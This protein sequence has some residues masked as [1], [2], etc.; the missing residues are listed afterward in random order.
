MP[1]NIYVNRP[2][3]FKEEC[4]KNEN[5]TSLFL[6]KALKFCTK[7]IYGNKKNDSWACV[8]EVIGV[9]E[10]KQFVI[11]G[12][13]SEASAKLVIED[14]MRRGRSC[15]GGP[16]V[17]MRCIKESA[18]SLNNLPSSAKMVMVNRLYTK[19]ELIA[20]QQSSKK[21]NGLGRLISHSVSMKK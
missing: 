6:A 9:I 5:V 14:Q 12:C 15:F 13:E 21:R 11:V 19:K 4:H 2:Y 20:M 17:L 3:E 1:Y 18:S 10:R 7:M 8:L 16:L